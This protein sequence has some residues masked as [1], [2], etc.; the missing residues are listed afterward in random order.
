MEEKLTKAQAD[1]ENPVKVMS[2]AKFWP[3]DY[4]QDDNC[5]PPSN[6]KGIIGG[7]VC[8]KPSRLLLVNHP[9]VKDAAACV[10]PGP[11][12]PQCPLRIHLVSCPMIFWSPAIF[13]FLDWHVIRLVPFKAEAAL[14]FEWMIKLRKIHMWGRC[15]SNLWADGIRLIRNAIFCDNS[16]LRAALGAFI[17]KWAKMATDFHPTWKFPNG[18]TE[19]KN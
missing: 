12:F 7:S 9:T 10:L 4:K 19:A 14:K 17:L 16:I 8:M 6:H 1:P 5:R 11:S 18:Q 15:L 13:G 2:N 3:P